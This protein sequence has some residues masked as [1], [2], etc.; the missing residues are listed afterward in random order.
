[1]IAF[2]KIKFYILNF[3]NFYNLETSEGKNLYETKFNWLKQLYI[4][5][6]N[7]C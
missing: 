4:L 7:Q 3:A 6:F 1:M 5:Y 2:T